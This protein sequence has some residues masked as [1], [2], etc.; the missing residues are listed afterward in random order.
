MSGG[1]ARA[2]AIAAPVV[3]ARPAEVVQAELCPTGEC[4]GNLQLQMQSMGSPW[5]GA[6]SGNQAM[7]RNA[8]IHESARQG[9]SGAGTALPY[10][11]QIQRSFG[12][13]DV[14][15]V[16]AHLGAEASSAAQKMGA[17]AF[18]TGNHVAFRGAPDLSLAAHEAAHVVQQRGGVQLSGGVGE[19]GDTY[20]QH[21]DRVAALVVQGRSSEAL[22][23]ENA[24]GTSIG[25]QLECASCPAG[26]PCECGQVQKQDPQGGAGGGVPYSTGGGGGPGTGG[27]PPLPH[28]V[29]SAY[30]PTDEE[31]QPLASTSAIETDAPPVKGKALKIDGFVLTDDEAFDRYQ[32]EQ[33]IAL[34]GLKAT[35]LAIDSLAKDL[36]TSEW[37]RSEQEKWG[38]GEVSGAPLDTELEDRMRAVLPVVKRAMAT[39][40]AECD[41]FLTELESTARKKMFDALD[42]SKNTVLSEASHYG[43]EVF[44]LD[45]GGGPT[46]H[47][48]KYST[49]RTAAD[50]IQEQRGQAAEEARFRNADPERKEMLK[51]AGELRVQKAAIKELEKKIADHKAVTPSNFLRDLDI[52]RQW[53]ARLANQQDEQKLYYAKREF[54]INLQKKAAKFPILGIFSRSDDE[55][56]ALA[57]ANI[58]DSNSAT[59]KTAIIEECNKRLRNIR[60]TRENMD[61]GKISPWNIAFVVEGTKRFL[62]VDP[63][64]MLA[65]VADDHVAKKKQ[66]IADEKAVYQ[67]E[68]TLALALSIAALI[69]TPAS[70]FLAAAG[71]VLGAHVAL[72]D[73]DVYL[74]ESAAAGTDFDKALSISQEDPSLFWLAVELIGTALDLGMAAKSLRG[75]ASARR[76]V[77]AGEHGAVDLLRS[78]AKAAHLTETQIQDLIKGAERAGAAERKAAVAEGQLV[79]EE[80]AKAKT[81]AGKSVERGGHTYRVLEDGRIVRCSEWCATAEMLFGHRPQ[82]ADDIKKLRGL[83]DTEAAEAFAK[84]NERAE[85][86][87]KAEKLSLPDLE[88]EIDKFPKGT[89]AGEDLRYVRYQNYKGGTR[90]FDEWLEVSRGGRHGG[91]VHQG[92]V[93]DIRNRFPGSER[94]FSEGKRVAD[95]FTPKGQGVPKDTYHQVGDVN[96]VRGD[97]IARERR[98][99]ED[100]RAAVGND[101][102]II[103]YPKSTPSSPL[104]NPDLKPGWIS[105]SVE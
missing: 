55:L 4:A 95:A 18:T 75:I 1:G 8:A 68:S 13:H 102:D 54:N 104:V 78:E 71:T 42:R 88:K 87:A 50:V 9:T 101:A 7:Q 38:A 65:R 20:E 14:R 33:H 41:E 61:A 51:A 26:L 94:E 10:L 96:A 22:L 76:A 52:R 35:S 79:A 47:Q 11:D 73:L 36:D 59:V 89:P 93:K 15:Q 60:E 24:E 37:V 83:P 30:I 28:V 2:T 82:L 74:V 85:R 12:R 105:P 32:L 99:I 34:H 58:G 63:G 80:V 57:T 16:Q 84:L 39:L 81:V 3:Q 48:T 25:V 66:E 103:F 45:L 53:T 86:I 62:K 92:I 72:H 17:N 98:A 19:A 21:A 64:T 91:P 6:P 49:P 67:A 27:P 23:D 90:S 97:P 69:P 56:G 29:T 70:P 44:Q 46:H 43:I 31:L 100:L 40:R 77:A 5:A